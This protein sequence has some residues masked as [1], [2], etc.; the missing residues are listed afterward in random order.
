[1]AAMGFRGALG[2]PMPA[3]RNYK[4]TFERP[5]SRVAAN[6]A[7]AAAQAAEA[8]DIDAS[9]A[10]GSRP[11][12][13][14]RRQH[15]SDSLSLLDSTVVLGGVAGWGR[16]TIGALRHTHTPAYRPDSCL[17]DGPVI[18]AATLD[19]DLS[20]RD[21]STGDIL[22]YDSLG[23]K[24]GQVFSLQALDVTGDGVD[25][26]IAC[27]WDGRTCI[28]DRAL[29]C[30]VHEFEDRVVAFRACHL[31]VSSIGDARV[32]G[33]VGT[34]SGQQ[35]CLVYA[36]NSS[37][38]VFV[39]GT[40]TAC[41]EGAEG[42]LDRPLHSSLSLELHDEVARLAGRTDVSAGRPVKYVR[43]PSLSDVLSRRSPDLVDSI[44]RIA[45]ESLGRSE[46]ITFA[47]AV[48]HLLKCRRAL[49]KD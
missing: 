47:V 44:L 12:E 5:M 20:V 10:A 30:T 45:R 43:P 4:S 36:T 17:D 28:F 9:Q 34:F 19:G 38:S 39:M 16:S 29:N 35:P 13:A 27:S 1:M 32:E 8:S 21:A 48:K 41:S 22:W 15:E 40:T 33:S 23:S 42:S 37:I 24:R 11:P 7:C 14:R 26:L 31:S 18:V 6:V 49:H 2:G 46:G 3:A 25:E